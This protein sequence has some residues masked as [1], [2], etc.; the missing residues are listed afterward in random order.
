MSTPTA[1]LLHKKER[2]KEERNKERAK[3]KGRKKSP[4]NWRCVTGQAVP[5]TLRYIK[6]KGLVSGQLSP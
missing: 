4:D 1:E 5:F 6:K 2:R 3:R